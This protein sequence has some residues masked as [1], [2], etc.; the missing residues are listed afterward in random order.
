MR[1]AC[2]IPYSGMGPRNKQTGFLEV[3]VDPNAPLFLGLNII[4]LTIAFCIFYWWGASWGK[5]LTIPQWKAITYIVAGGL[6]VS[7][8][9][10]LIYGSH[11]EI[12]EVYEDSHEG[13]WVQDFEVS[14]KERV[15]Y[16]LK[17]F[18]FFLA[19]SLIGYFTRRKRA[20]ESLESYEKGLE[21]MQVHTLTR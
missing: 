10:M 19:T 21:E 16:G 1:K 17:I 2:T 6:I 3:K 18:L 7:A 8:F 20:Q 14:I 15:L 4:E 9:L 11:Y 12:Y 13:E 5:D